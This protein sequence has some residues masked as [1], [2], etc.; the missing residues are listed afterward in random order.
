MGLAGFESPRA[1]DSFFG[2]PGEALP[3][4]SSRCAENCGI[5]VSIFG[6]RRALS[7]DGDGVG[8]FEGGDSSG[9]GDRLSR[10]SDINE[11]T[12]GR[13]HVS[14]G[15]RSSAAGARQSKGLPF[16]VCRGHHKRQGVYGAE[17]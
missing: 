13:R 16:Q 6:G 12:G 17:F 3:D 9:P 4:S 5:S 15:L 8:L 1:L 11:R 2:E 7:P 14:H 10:H